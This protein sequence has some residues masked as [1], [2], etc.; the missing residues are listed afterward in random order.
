MKADTEHRCENPGC[1]KLL[2]GRRKDTKFCN[3]K[4]RYQAK[5]AEKPETGDDE[6]VWI[7][8]AC[9]YPKLAQA[10][11]VSKAERHPY[12]GNRPEWS[13]YCTIAGRQPMG[14]DCPCHVT[15]AA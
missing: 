1:H 9:K 10:E 3:L 13:G 12:S 4:C 14:C 15:E 7:S 5:Q 11:I 6:E 2:K 8:Q